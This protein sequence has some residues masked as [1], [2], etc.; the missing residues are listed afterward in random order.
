M[1]LKYLEARITAAEGRARQRRSSEQQ[2]FHL[3][4]ERAQLQLKQYRARVDIGLLWEATSPPPLLNRRDSPPKCVDEVDVR[5][6]SSPAP[7][8][9]APSLIQLPAASQPLTATNT[10]AL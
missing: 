1:E 4:V 5:N 8:S 3:L 7:A 9:S 2:V 10:V 6:A